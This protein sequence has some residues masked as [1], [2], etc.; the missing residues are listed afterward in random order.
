MLSEKKGGSTPRIMVMG[1]GRHGKDTVSEML[2]ELR[3]LKYV[4]SS[5]F[6]AENVVMPVFNGKYDS[7]QECYDDRHNHR[8]TWFEAIRDYNRADPTRLGRA[9]FEE[10]DIYCG[11][12]NKTEFQALK[13]ARLLDHS[14]WVDASDRHPAESTAS[15]SVEPWMAD[16]VI[17]NNGSEADLARNVKQW[18][19]AWL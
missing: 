14:I 8:T 17:D 16:F 2:C 15:C 9:I 10:K 13:N 1:Y 18:A 11:I 12:R 19:E 6:C 3:G 5:L 7:A 4:S